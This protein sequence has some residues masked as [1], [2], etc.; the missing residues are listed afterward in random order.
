MQQIERVGQ[1]DS[2]EFRSSE[3]SG[4]DFM[5]LIASNQTLERLVIENTV[6]ANEKSSSTLLKMPNYPEAFLESN[7]ASNIKEFQWCPI[8][9]TYNVNAN[10][11]FPKADF[12][13]SF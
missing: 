12:W 10:N 11:C 9:D 7:G 4:M 13:R 8:N 6:S 1:V 2:L 5:K 3:A